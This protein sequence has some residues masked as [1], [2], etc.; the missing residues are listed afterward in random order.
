MAKRKS[1]TANRARSVSKP[2]RTPGKS[3][4]ATVYQLKITLNDIRPPVW[5][6]VQTKDCTLAQLHD[7][8]QTVMG[9]ED[10]HLHEFEVGEERY[11]LPEQWES[12]LHEP[13]VRNSRKIKL[14]QIVE[15]GVKKFQYQYDMGDSWWHTI[16]IEKLLTAEPDV[17]YPRCIDGKRAC[18]PEDCGGPWGYAD[19]VEA[20]QNPNHERHDELLEWI[21]GE[22]DP[23]AF[24]LEAVN[25]ELKG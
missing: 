1:T 24:D 8:I 12:G 25:E 19:F 22:F 15:Q 14:S 3:A 18:P 10:Y 4:T 17:K 7:I 16:Q 2:S 20:I 9:W 11:G 23:E 6:R 5:R 21:G 13:E